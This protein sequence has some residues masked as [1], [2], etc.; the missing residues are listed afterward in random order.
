[1]VEEAAVVGAAVHLLPTEEMVM[2]QVELAGPD[3]AKK[4]VHSTLKSTLVGREGLLRIKPDYIPTL[5]PSGQ[6]DR[7]ILDLWDGVVSV[8]DIVEEIHLRFPQNSPRATKSR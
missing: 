4:F 2:W 7:A 1:V 6:I 3:V 8:R 5:S